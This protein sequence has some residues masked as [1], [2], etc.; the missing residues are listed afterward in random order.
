MTS[1]SDTSGLVREI[2]RDALKRDPKRFDMSIEEKDGKQYFNSHGRP[3]ELQ[4]VFYDADAKV[5]WMDRVGF[6]IAAISVGPP[7][8]F[9][10]LSPD[11]GL[12][13]A[14]LANYA[15][16]VVVMKMGTATVSNEEL[17]HAIERDEELLT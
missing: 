17:R 7:I 6:D 11:K 15:G 3:A 9:Y 1:N 12:E 5:E 13:A 2:Y 10:W 8:Y 16:G 14:K 4:P